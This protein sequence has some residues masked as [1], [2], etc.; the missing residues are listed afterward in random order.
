MTPGELTR[1]RARK[2]RSGGTS[3]YYSSIRKRLL[4]ALKLAGAAGLDAV[5]LDAGS[6]AKAMAWA[7]ALNSPSTL[8]HPVFGSWAARAFPN[9]KLRAEWIGD[10]LIE[11]EVP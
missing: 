5:V 7:E 4:P 3:A 6:F 2:R 8:M 9:G 1:D 10:P 11:E